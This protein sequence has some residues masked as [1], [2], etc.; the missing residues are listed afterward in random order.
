MAGVAKRDSAAVAMSISII[1]MEILTRYKRNK[2]GI[3][4]LK[5]QAGFPRE[6]VGPAAL[7]VLRNRL[8]KAWSN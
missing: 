4:V 2:R 8:G 7:K 6:T 3:R 5:Y 1:V